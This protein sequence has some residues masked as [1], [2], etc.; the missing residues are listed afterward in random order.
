MNLD[1]VRSIILADGGVPGE[2]VGSPVSAG[3]PVKTPVTR[4]YGCTVKYA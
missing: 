1:E 3:Q 4:A 2:W